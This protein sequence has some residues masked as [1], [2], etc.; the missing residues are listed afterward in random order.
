[1]SSATLISVQEY[2]STSYRPDRDF[3]DGE[4]Q[5]RNLGELEHSLL[6]TAIAACFWGRKKEWNLVPVVEQRV[7]VAPTR[8]RVPDVTV[9]RSDQAREPIITKPPLIL[10]EV[11]SK[12]DTLRSMQER[13]DDYLHFGVQHVWILDPAT[14]RAYVC[15]LT[16]FQEPERGVLVVPGT[17]I[18]LVLSELF[19]Q[20]EPLS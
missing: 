17:P 8:F 4:V 3:V 18:R 19:N 12:D 15:S 6:Q 16:G 13:V 1:M 11:L 7:Q 5:E 10:I 20:V 9:L 14:R 2:L